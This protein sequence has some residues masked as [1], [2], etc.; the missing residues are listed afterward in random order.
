MSRAKAVSDGY[1]QVTPY[2]CVEGATAAI[3]FYSGVFGAGERMRMD[4]PDGKI[5]HAELTIGDSLIM[6]SDEYPE[7]NALGPKA[8]GVT[9]VTISIY[10][11]EWTRPSNVRYGPAGQPCAPSR[12]SSTA[13][14][15]VSSRTRSGTGGAS[16]R[17]SRTSH[18]MR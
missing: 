9:P 5:G 7:M 3:E 14:V 17:A 12:T 13:I 6:L 2:L 8:I 4:G 1:P 15:R 18:L 11:E 10:V 16:R